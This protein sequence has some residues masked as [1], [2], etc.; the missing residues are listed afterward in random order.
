MKRVVQVSS[1]T[2][3]TAEV[4]PGV[5]RLSLSTRTR[6][7]P[8]SR[9]VSLDLFGVNDRDEVVWLHDNVSVFWAHKGPM[10]GRDAQIYEGMGQAQA[11]VK[12][13]L[14]GQG[15]QVRGGRYAVPNDVTPLRGE[16]ECVRWVRDEDGAYRV[17]AGGR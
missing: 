12:A 1:L 4:E 11:L 9:D 8:P 2:E 6:P 14:E 7:T 15:Y 13:H 10:L 16:F 3:F 5:V 17:E